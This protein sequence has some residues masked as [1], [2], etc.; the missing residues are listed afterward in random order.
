MAGFYLFVSSEDSKQYHTDNT[1]HDFIVELGRFYDLNEQVNRRGR[2]QWSAALVEIKLESISGSDI[3][4]LKEPVYILCDILSPSFIKG[5]ERSILRPIGVNQGG[6]FESLYQPFYIQ[7]NSLCFSRLK[8][9]IV[10]QNL[11]SLS[12]DKGW[13]IGSDWKLSC[14]LH[15]Q[16][17]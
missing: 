6:Q 13:P 12:E 17:M 14:I 10:D 3:P 8:I 16:K 15:F 5:T 1:Y 2:G 11:Q 4:A 9:A 7:L